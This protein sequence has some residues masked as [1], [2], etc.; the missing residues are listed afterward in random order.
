MAGK[1]GVYGRAYKIQ[2]VKQSKEIGGAK[3]AVL[4]IPIY[5]VRLGK[6]GARRAVGRESRRSYAG[7]GDE[8]G[9]GGHLQ[10][11]RWPCS[12]E[13]D[14]GAEGPRREWIS[15]VSGRCAGD[16][17]G[18]S[19]RKMCHLVL[20]KQFD[21][22]QNF[23][24]GKISEKPSGSLQSSNISNYNFLLSAPGLHPAVLWGRAG[25]RLRSQ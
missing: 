6:S 11:Y 13:S 10:R 14:A 21:Y 1:Q 17:A 19:E 12:V 20:T 23:A 7:G 9:G 24:D 8:S 3:A 15:P 5:I 4:G 2:A 22:I 25:L 16:G 18:G